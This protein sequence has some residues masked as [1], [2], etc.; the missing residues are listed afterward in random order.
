MSNNRLIQRLRQMKKRYGDNLYE[1]A[2]DALALDREPV[3]WIIRT[4]SGGI[5]HASKYD[6]WT[7]DAVMFNETAQLALFDTEV[8][9]S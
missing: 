8:T 1:E 5:I 6:G 7:V 2:A 4:P 3:G 9:E